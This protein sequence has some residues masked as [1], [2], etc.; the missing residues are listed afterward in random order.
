MRAMKFNGHTHTCTYEGFSV[1]YVP[2]VGCIAVNIANPS[3]ELCDDSDEPDHVRLID[4]WHADEA[5]RA[6]AAAERGEAA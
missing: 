1:E 3:I 2:H 5:D 4:Q 6:E